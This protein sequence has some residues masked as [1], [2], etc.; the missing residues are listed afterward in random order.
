MVKWGVTTY[1]VRDIT[2][3][4]YN[5]KSAPNVTHA[6]GTRLVVEYIEA[7]WCPTIESKQLAAGK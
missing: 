3:A 2:D 5:P 7:H 6:D 1:L 4:M